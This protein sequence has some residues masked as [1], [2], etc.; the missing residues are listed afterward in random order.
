[1]LSKPKREGD[2]EFSKWGWKGPTPGTLNKGGHP[3][4]GGEKSRSHCF[5]DTGKG[6]RRVD[7]KE[8]PEQGKKK[9]PITWT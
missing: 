3:G 7:I 6:P 5:L 9:Q 2:E 1:V 4:G 8:I